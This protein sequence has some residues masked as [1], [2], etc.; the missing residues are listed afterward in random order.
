LY[1]AI[2]LAVKYLEG[3]VNKQENNYILHPL[4]VMMKIDSLKAK[5]V[6]VLKVMTLLVK[7]VRF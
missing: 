3:Q 1:K 2:Y 6:A 7:G 5:I 4:S